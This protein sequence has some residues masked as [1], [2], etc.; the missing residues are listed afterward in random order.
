MTMLADEKPKTLYIDGKWC[1][2]SERELISRNPINNDV[3]W[4]G[5]T[6]SESDVDNAVRAARRAYA[7]WVSK[8]IDERIAVLERFN[9]LLQAKKEIIALAIHTEA[10]KALWDSQAEVN[11]MLGKLNISIKAFLERTG[12]HERDASGA[13]LSHRGIG[14]LAVLGPFNF[15]GHL[16][17][18]HIIPALLA[19]NTVVFKPSE[20][21]PGVGQLI[22]EFW[23]DAG[24]PEGVFNLVQGSADCGTWLASHA[25]LDGLLFTGSHRAGKALHRLFADSPN[26][27]LAL[28]MGGNNPLVISEAGDI[29][30]TAYTV[31]QSA[32][33]S[34]GQRCTCARRLILH[35]QPRNEQIL[36][37]LIEMTKKIRVGSDSDCFIGSL[38][39]IN[40]A[41]TALEF[42]QALI[43]KGAKPLL[44][45][46]LLEPGK[47]LMQPG[48]IDISD[49]EMLDDNECF[50][51]LL[52]VK[53]V[54]S[55]DDAIEAANDTRFGLAAGLLSESETLW[56]Q[57]FHSS[58]A[59]IINW[60]RPLTGASSAMPFGGSGDS[61]NFRPSAYYAADYCAYPIASL[62][63]EQLMLPEKL[64]PGLLL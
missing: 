42:E 41:N 58:R 40:A 47:P 13:Q 61:G 30:A 19:G 27:I 32:F 7:S 17:N 18:G 54:D 31:L 23:H 33:V 2:G 29:D 28:E 36:A 20:H 35:R 34:A 6:A 63:S 8:S 16:P 56:Q 4:S 49:I 37:R 38:I 57:F 22:T 55:F 60:N 24:L 26:K 52:Q 64:S 15:P 53:W 46:T 3:V 10:G 44:P 51:P 50:G 59:G 9:Q 62:Q 43:E 45:L 48:I 5:Q 21:C 12:N 1:T 11:A 25:E 39:N 14:V